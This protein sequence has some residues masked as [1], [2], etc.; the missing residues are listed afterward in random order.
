MLHSPERVHEI[1]AMATTLTY[2]EVAQ[3]CGLTRNA[4]AGIVHRAMGRG[5][6]GGKK[7]RTPEIQDL[8]D[9]RE[10]V[11]LQVLQAA[12]EQRAEVEK[13]RIARGLEAR[14]RQRAEARLARDNLRT[15]KGKFLKLDERMELRRQAET[16]GS[17]NVD[18]MTLARG[19]CRFPTSQDR[20]FLFCGLPADTGQSYCDCHAAV[21]YKGNGR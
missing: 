16:I 8:R 4:V 15:V 11:R 6:V 1:V 2:L 12:A 18:F 17:R 7:Y 13:A 10:K 19:E 21:A 9:A 20:P 3:R 14:M 5:R